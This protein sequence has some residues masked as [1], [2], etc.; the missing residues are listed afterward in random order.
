MSVTLG[1]QHSTLII[2]CLYSLLA[3]VSF[4]SIT[5]F[6]LA[7]VLMQL[8]IILHF[9]FYKDWFHKAT[10]FHSVW[11]EPPHPPLVRFRNATCYSKQPRNISGLPLSKFSSFMSQ[12]NTVLLDGPAWSGYSWVACHLRVLCLQ[13]DGQE[14]ER[15]WK[16]AQIFHGQAFKWSVSLFPRSHWPHSHKTPPRYKGNWE[17]QASSIPKERK[18]DWWAFSHFLPHSLSIYISIVLLSYI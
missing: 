15:E 13:A 11:M 1:H 14:N 10:F 17:I 5:N 8:I 3:K 2:V 12:N 16:T 18:Q 9:C 4:N 6:N 7:A